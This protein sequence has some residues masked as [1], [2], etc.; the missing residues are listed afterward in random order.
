M[1]FM[2]FIFCLLVLTTLHAHA[3]DSTKLYD[4][5]A[6][7]AKDVAELLVKAK[8]ENKHVLLVVGGNWCI[9][10][11]K[12]NAFVQLDT[13]LK[14][15]VAENYEVYHLNYSPE[16]KNEAYL[17]TLGNPQRFGFPVLVVLD[18]NGKQLHTQNTALLEKGNGYSFD[19]VKDF[20]L[21]WAP[22]K[23]Q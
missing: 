9:W 23:S 14:K 15:L 1:Y 5:R 18:E 17:K 16:N 21:K 7:V 22:D 2:R 10:C 12:L 8:Q 19:K 11:Y 13:V 4:P 6:N 3:G 20:L